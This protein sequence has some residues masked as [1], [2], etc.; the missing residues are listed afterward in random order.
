MNFFL[1]LTLFDVTSYSDINYLLGGFPVHT[2][3]GYPMTLDYCRI[4]IW[5]VEQRNWSFQIYWDI[6]KYNLLWFYM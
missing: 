3:Y 2:Y 5:A 1:A 4:I 6:S